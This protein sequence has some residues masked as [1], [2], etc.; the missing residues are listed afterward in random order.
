[1][2]SPIVLILAAGLGTRMKSDRAKVLHEVAGR[3]L[4]AWAVESARAAGAARIIAILGH[5][6]ERVRDV[7]DARY[8]KGAVEVAHQAEQKG[9]GHAVMCALPGLEKERDDRTVVILSG[10]APLLLPS[11]LGE[12]AEACASS[13]SKMALL[14]TRAD[15]PVAYGKLV[16]DAHGKLARIVEHKDASAEERQIE[17]VNAGNYAIALGHL[18]KDAAALRADNAQGELYLT[19]LAARAHERGGAAVIEVSFAE[20]SGVNDRI[21]LAAVDAMARRRINEELMRSG[22]TMVAPDQVFVDAD[23]GPIGSD[24]W[25]GPGVQVRGRSRIGR[26]ARIDSGCLIQESEIGDEVCVHPYSVLSHVLV[27]ARAV[28]GPFAHCRAESRVDEE[29]H[30]GNFV[31]TRR[32]HL[33]AGSRV[34]QLAYIGDA[35][36]GARAV[37]GAGTIT[38]DFDG[39][40]FSRT[41][42]EAGAFVG[43]GAQLVAP[44]TIGRDAYVGAGTTVTRDVPRGALALSRVKQVN[45]EGWADRFREA[46]GKRRGPTQP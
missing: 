21:D 15:R 12:L 18:R 4:I 33:M 9:T 11:R 44:T 38:C 27:G 17:E 7:L 8:G 28:I 10:D 32:A 46:I 2:A 40:A 26:A 43:S 37:V 3:P 20:T 6:L 13:R 22:V 31:E 16:R 24:T 35:A 39:L 30:V 23:A 1:M 45:V 19:D 36:V 41:V 14:S 29:A 34:E 42:I 5:Q 25:L